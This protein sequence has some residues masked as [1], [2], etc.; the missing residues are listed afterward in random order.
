MQFLSNIPKKR[1]IFIKY[2]KNQLDHLVVDKDIAKKVARHLEKFVFV[3]HFKK[4][5]KVL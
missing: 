5:R 4:E 1:K 2:S 3:S